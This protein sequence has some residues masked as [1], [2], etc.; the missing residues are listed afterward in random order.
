MKGRKPDAVLS[1]H[2]ASKTR[3]ERL[4]IPVWGSAISGSSDVVGLEKTS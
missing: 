2:L 4:G 3:V 1:A